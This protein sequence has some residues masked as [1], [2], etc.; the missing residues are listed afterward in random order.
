MKFWSSAWKSSSQPRKQRKY[1]YHAPIHI[2]KKFI[3]ATLSKELREKYGRRSITL[4]KGDEV[5]IMR[6]EFKGK[7][8]KINRIEI[9]KLK[10]YIDGITRKKVDGSD[11][12]V[13]IHPSNLRVINL[14]LKDERR[15]KKLNK[16]KER[17]KDGEKASKKTESSKVLGD[18][19]KRK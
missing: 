18:K 7:R 16:S 6:G 3:S 11:I 1:V 19:K 9:K 12:S 4:R 14:E 15:L 10:V 2:K 5:E 8:G 17:E 13:P